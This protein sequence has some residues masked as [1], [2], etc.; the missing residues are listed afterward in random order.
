[1]CVVCVCEREIREREREANTTEI[2]LTV[3]AR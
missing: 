2:R 3:P 1:M